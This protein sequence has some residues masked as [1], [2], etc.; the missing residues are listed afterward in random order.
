MTDGPFISFELS[1]DLGFVKL[2]AQNPTP[3]QIFDI[4]S[5]EVSKIVGHLFVNESSVLNDHAPFKRCLRKRK[6]F[7][8]VYK[9]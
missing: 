8:F 3:K 6:C 9:S 1:L 4:T 7:H 2:C 5:R